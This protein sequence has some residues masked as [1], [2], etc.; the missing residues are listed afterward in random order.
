MGTWTLQQL[1][2]ASDVQPNDQF[3]TSVAISGDGLT[4]ISGD[5]L[6]NT[7]GTDAGAAY[8]S[9]ES[10]G[11]WTEQQKITPISLV[12]TI[13]AFGFDICM[14]RCGTRMIT[15]EPYDDEAAT[16]SGAFYVF[17]Y[18]SDQWLFKSVTRLSPG[19]ANAGLGV[20]C[21]I[22]DAGTICVVGA[23][24]E[25][26][27]SGNNYGAAYVYNIDDCGSTTLVQKLVSP[28]MDINN[29][30]YN[31]GRCV[32][33]NGV[34]NL[35]AVGERYESIN[36]ANQPEYINIYSFDGMTWN[37]DQT[38]TSPVT[39]SSGYGLDITMNNAGTI[40]AI[41]AY[42][43]DDAGI[44][45]GAAYVYTVDSM[46][47]WSQQQKIIGN[48]TVAGDRFGV[49]VKLSG[50]GKILAIGADGDDDLNN[51]TGS[52][53]IFKEPNGSGT[54]WVQNQKISVGTQ[55]AARLGRV[56]GLDY[57]G[58][59]LVVGESGQD[60]SGVDRG[61]IRIY[62]GFDNTYVETQNI[63]GPTD[64]GLIGI[65]VWISSC[66]NKIAAG[67]TGNLSNG[68]NV[69]AYNISDTT[70]SVKVIKH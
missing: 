20:S 53:Y 18:Q 65:G 2:E 27:L 41:T 11:T 39:T 51:N 58:Y 14:N 45:A 46:G 67:A 35:I 56:I 6:K 28:N 68:G 57:T 8:I 13:S 42:T 12:P 29:T 37:L 52:V 21:A 33:I 47:V 44:N 43:D 19:V 30:S 50:D 64:N 15:G 63:T 25:P 70:Q 60:A 66:G 32:A 4:I 69:F 48:D 40:I 10:M 49:D 59:R 24:T 23:F 7:A 61:R 17:D 1:I 5:P 26:N 55:S 38:I 31:Y 62:E 22:N 54:G 16:N 36:V 3:G 34:G 9:T